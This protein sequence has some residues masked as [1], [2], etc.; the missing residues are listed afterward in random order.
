MTDP[1]TQVLPPATDGTQP[2]CSWS[3]D[4]GEIRDELTGGL[5]VC[6]KPQGSVAH[7]HSTE[8]PPDHEDWF[9]C[10]GFVEPAT[11]A[12]PPATEER[13]CEVF[14]A[15]D[16]LPAIRKR[17]TPPAPM[18]GI[19]PKEWD[20]FEAA[21]TPPAP[22]PSAALVEAL[23]SGFTSALYGFGGKTGMDGK[24]V[25]LI[26][27]EAMSRPSIQRVLAAARA[28]GLDGLVER[29]GAVKGEPGGVRYVCVLPPH[30]WDEGGHHLWP[31]TPPWNAARARRTGEGERG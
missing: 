25:P 17:P 20:D 19:T 4:A 5:F 10:H 21:A 26:V 27:A 23:V 31:D 12:T 8:C 28:E 3:C 6:N 13:E 16:G 29:C 22:E 14:I 18:D 9:A 7:S 11:D 15:G 1:A 24:W 30:S 2:R